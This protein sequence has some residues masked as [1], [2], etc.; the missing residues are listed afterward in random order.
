MTN[1]KKTS[2]AR[3]FWIDCQMVDAEQ[4]DIDCNVYVRPPKHWPRKPMRN[5]QFHV[6][7]IEALEAAQKRIL[8]L[9]AS[10]AEAT[11]VLKK[12]RDYGAKYGG[13]DCL[14][15]E[16]GVNGLLDKLALSQEPGER[17]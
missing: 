11:V 13:I 10:L 6:I 16:F 7:E 8:E 3:E 12:L 1:D 4:N 17:G 2:G 5:L 15:E 14:L 9:E